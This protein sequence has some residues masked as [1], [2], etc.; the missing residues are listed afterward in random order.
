VEEGRVFGGEEI[1]HSRLGGRRLIPMLNSVE[2]SIPSDNLLISHSPGRVKRMHCARKR[3]LSRIWRGWFYS[4]AGLMNQSGARD[5]DGSSQMGLWG[6]LFSWFLFGWTSFASASQPVVIAGP[7]STSVL[8]DQSASFSVIADGSPPLYYQWRRDGVPLANGTNDHAVVSH[9]RFLDQ[10]SYSVVVSN[11]E[12]AV[13]SAEAALSVTL[14]IAGD[15]DCSF[16]QGSGINYTARQALLQPNGKVVVIGSGVG[17]IYGWLR[18]YNVDGTIDDTFLRGLSGANDTIKACV[19]QSDGKLVIG[20]QF[21]AINGSVR[22]GIARLNPDGTLDP[23]FTAG[24]GGYATNVTII[25]LQNDGKLIVGGGFSTVNGTAREYLARLNPDG[26]LDNTFQPS[27]SSSSDVLLAA[28]QPD[29]KIIVGGYLLLDAKLRYVARLHPSGAL[30]AEFQSSATNYPSTLTVQNDGKVLVT[31]DTSLGRGIFRLNS[32]GTRDT[33]FQPVV[34]NEVNSVVVQ[35]D[36]KLLVGANGK[37]LARLNPSGSLDGT[38][39]SGLTGPNSQVFSIALDANEKIVIAGPFTGVNGVNRNYL[40]RLETDGRLDSTF[41]PVNP[42]PDASVSAIE[43]QSDSKILVAGAFSTF[44]GLTRNG[45]AR[46]S[47]DGTLDPS[48]ETVANGVGCMALQQDGKLVIGGSFSQVQGSNRA[49]IA[50]LHPDGTLDTAFQNGLCGFNDTVYSLALQSDGKAVVA[51]RYTSVNG[52]TRN[53][54]ARLNLDGTLDQDF[55]NALTGANA[56]IYWVIL[57]TNDQAILVGNFTSVNST[58]RNH[59]ARLNLDGTLDNTFQNGLLGANSIVYA[60]A[61]QPDGKI[62]IGGIFSN[63]NGVPR[64]RLARLNP[65]GTL[66]TGF[67][68]GV[69]GPDYDVRFLTLQSDGKVLVSGFFT[70]VNGVARHNMAR[71]NADGSLDGRFLSGLSGTLQ[72]VSAIAMQGDGKLLA[73]GG[74]SQFN[75]LAMPRLARLWGDA[76]SY[77]QSVNRLDENQVILRMHLPAGTTNRLQYKEN[78]NDPTWTDLPGE[79]VADGSTNLTTKLDSSA[80]GVQQRVYRLRQS[81]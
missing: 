69:S 31:P 65:D 63:V 51:G 59:V 55:Q 66:D 54:I 29:G 57:Q 36:G 20:G 13:T 67:F 30:D 8:L 58:T 25:V 45:V 79:I 1:L 9:A 16:L 49:R 34:S 6:V 46:L 14:P 19:V 15:I 53:R 81:R 41:E 24:V 56:S 3:S 75:E 26:T 78:L 17:S 44:N 35:A 40:A 47:P 74:F 60:V 18:R 62:V 76:P 22:N 42:G 27:F 72:G 71:L 43:I 37:P 80:G 38:F 52:V 11:L 33:G 28:T 73:G 10:G 68:E 12:G 64:N 32:D 77:L 48:F 21:K 2:E 4:F 5:L 50:R 70:N 61:V 7:R 39:L 23:G